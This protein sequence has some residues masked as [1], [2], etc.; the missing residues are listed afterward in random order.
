M[1]TSILFITFA[2]SFLMFCNIFVIF[3]LCI[4]ISNSS[5]RKIV[6]VATSLI[7][8]SFNFNIFLLFSKIILNIIN[9][10]N[11]RIFIMFLHAV[12]M[13]ATLNSRIN[14]IIS[15]TLIFDIH[16]FLKFSLFI[17]LVSF[18]Y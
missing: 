6:I 8:K 4:I 14:I 12:N 5:R 18:L 17:L 10:L 3:I 2:F 7:Q 16:F 11:F 1:M 13:I 9:L 15:F